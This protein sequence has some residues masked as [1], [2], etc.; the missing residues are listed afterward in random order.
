M[1]GK[2]NVGKRMKEEGIWG[3]QEGL[4][5]TSGQ[6]TL[7]GWKIKVLSILQTPRCYE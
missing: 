2:I 7:S 1:G 3:N 5:N 6:I 4:A